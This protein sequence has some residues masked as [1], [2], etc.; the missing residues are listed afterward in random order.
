MGNEISGSFWANDLFPYGLFV[1]LVDRGCTLMSSESCKFQSG[2][3][4]TSLSV[5]ILSKEYPRRQVYLLF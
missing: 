2:N 1:G 4:M 3:G 5:V